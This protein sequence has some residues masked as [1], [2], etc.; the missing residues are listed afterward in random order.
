MDGIKDPSAMAAWSDGSAFLHE[1]KMEAYSKYLVRSR[2]PDGEEK[3]P[4]AGRFIM[5]DQKNIQYD[6]LYAK[7]AMM[8]A[9]CQTKD[10]TAI[11]FERNAGPG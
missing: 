2:D 3:K 6:G 11:F 9:S 8:T 4:R 5:T 7:K 10:A 1:K